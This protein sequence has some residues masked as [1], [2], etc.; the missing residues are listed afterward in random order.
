[1]NRKNFAGIMMWVKLEYFRPRVACVGEVEQ[2][3]MFNCT[4]AIAPPPV[5]V[6]VAVDRQAFCASRTSTVW[7]L[8]VWDRAATRL[9]HQAERTK[10]RQTCFAASKVFSMAR[11]IPSSTWDRSIEVALRSFAISSISAITG[12]WRLSSSA[13]ETKDGRHAEALAVTAKYPRKTQSAF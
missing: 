3:K 9:P 13:E 4:T 1:M 11:S 2:K 12:L 6:L 8:Q 5:L 10:N 7:R